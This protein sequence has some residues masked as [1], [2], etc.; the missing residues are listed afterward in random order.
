[1]PFPKTQQKSSAG[2]FSTYTLSA[3]HSATMP[4]PSLLKKR[5]S[6]ISSNHKNMFKEKVNEGKTNT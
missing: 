5:E 4:K 3:E 6:A 2:F 1:M